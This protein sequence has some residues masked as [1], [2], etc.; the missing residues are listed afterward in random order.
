MI[1]QE[2]ETTLEAARSKNPQ[3]KWEIL[4]KRIKKVSLNFSRSIVSE[5]KLIIEQ[6]SETV[7]EYESRLPLPQEEEEI[8]AS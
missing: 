3:E 8:K 4:K 2:I 6:L 7:N 5:E 1:N